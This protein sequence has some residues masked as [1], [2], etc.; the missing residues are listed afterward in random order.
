[1]GPGIGTGT[2]LIFIYVDENSDK[3][4]V[5]GIIGTGCSLVYANPSHNGYVSTS[6]Y[7]SGEATQLKANL[8]NGNSESRNY[9]LHFRAIKIAD[10]YQE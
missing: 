5:T 3:W 4:S 9:N 6:G 8:Y 10:T 2:W 7:Y 1:M